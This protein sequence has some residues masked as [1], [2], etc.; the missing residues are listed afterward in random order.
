MGDPGIGAGATGMLR[1]CWVPSVLHY[2]IFKQLHI[3]VVSITETE[4][5]HLE[6]VNCFLKERY[7]KITILC[8][9]INSVLVMV[10]PI[11]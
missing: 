2:I 5:L 10:S 11:W 3:S 8:V 6:H 4:N 7:Q 9:H 1:S